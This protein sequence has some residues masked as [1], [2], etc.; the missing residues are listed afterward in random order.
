MPQLPWTRPLWPV[1][2]ALL[3]ALPAGS[4]H[5]ARWYEVELLVFAREDPAAAI[6]EQW[7]PLPRLAYP[8]AARFLVD[9]ARVAANRAAHPGTS[10]LDPYG[11]QIITLAAEPTVDVPAPVN[12]PAPIVA[13]EAASPPPV[14]TPEPAAAG[15]AA[16][17]GTAQAPETP[18]PYLVLPAQRRE[19][20]GS[21]ARMQR[22]GR[23]SILFHQA[24][25]Q[26]IG[27]AGK[28]LPIV[29]DDSGDSGQW[30]RLQGSIRLYSS[31]YLY[32]E[33][34]L[35]LNTDG[36]YLPGQWRMDP[37]PLGPPSLV[38][39][40]PFPE[41]VAPL[42][43]GMSPPTP[44]TQTASPGGPAPLSP[45]V[46]SG[47]AAAGDG[48]EAAADEQAEP[49]APVY[50]WRHA[51]LL[52][53]KRRMRNAEANYLDHPLFGAIIKVTPLDAPALQALALEETV[54]AP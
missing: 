42:Q 31:R 50:P 28:S 20:N 36:S 6:A 5:A 17:T 47:P 35:W 1:A 33:T 4:A 27:G 10:A 34:D 49:P 38:V 25:V 12:V 32:L 29:I 22:S 19:F 53:Q 51:V 40:V 2:F 52:Q 44:G 30:P 46:E 14:A 37:P 48:E 13:P 54:Q 26:P 39:E 41:P 18:T 8:A 45:I 43:A 21:A 16:D 24:W 11:R 23:F 15:P 7:D 3:A 9:P